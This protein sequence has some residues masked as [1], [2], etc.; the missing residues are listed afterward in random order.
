MK[1]NL[2]KQG[3][4]FE[5]NHCGTLDERESA[6]PDM[7]ICRISES[8]CVVSPYAAEF[9]ETFFLENGIGFTVGN[10]FLSPEYPE[11]IAYNVSVGDKI[12]FHNTKHTDKTILEML[13]NSGKRPVN[14][15]QGYSGCSSIFADVKV[16]TSDYGIFKTCKK[17]NIT[18]VLFKEPKQILLSGF[19]N[20]FMGGSC[21]YSKETGLLINCSEEYL[22][23]DFR[24]EL[25]RQNIKYTC[26]GSGRITD[27]GGILIFTGH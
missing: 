3:S 5:L 26:V 19:A 20:G 18:A 9:V 11:N 7:H 13:I 27:I 6:H 10:T 16:I 15:K 25:D 22:P 24:C 2:R 14:V 12:F 17:E 23:S 1:D 4:V 8:F 21:G